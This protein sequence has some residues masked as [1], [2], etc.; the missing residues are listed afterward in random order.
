MEIVTIPAQ[1]RARWD[2]VLNDFEGVS[3]S[4]SISISD[5]RIHDAVCEGPMLDVLIK[6]FLQIFPED[7]RYV[8][9]IR[10]CAQRQASEG[11]SVIVHQRVFELDGVHVGFQLFNYLAR[12]NFG[13]GRYVGFLP[14]HRG[15]GFYRLVHENTMEILRAD[16]A[17]LG[18]PEPLGFCAEVDSPAA[19]ET[20]E[21]HRI[22]E[23]RILVFQRLG[24]KLLDVDYVEPP[25]IQG[26]S[27]DDPQ[28]MEEA[29]PRPMHL[30]FFPMSPQDPF[31][32][33]VFRALVLGVLV[34]NYRY[35]EDSPVVQRVLSSIK[36]ESVD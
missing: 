21:E 19:A 13:F 28:V 17:S 20:E 6:L 33:D 24:G 1:E 36:T 18:R 32:A 31:D 8:G 10:E 22:R 30:C 5:I 4:S 25:A 3:L 34:D 15:N 29:E 11:E 14:V 16:A 9:Y 2:R 12:R 27:V 23:K 35:S 7:R 26:M